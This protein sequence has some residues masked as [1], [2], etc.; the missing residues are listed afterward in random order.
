MTEDKPLSAADE[1]PGGEPYYIDSTCETCGTELVLYAEFFEKM[2]GT[3]HDEWWCP[4]CNDG[5]RMDWPE[6]EEEAVFDDADG[7]T[8]TSIQDDDGY[9]E[10]DETEE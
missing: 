1:R 2:G 9:E 6:G 10:S 3:F 4:E 7:Q 5:I 8:W